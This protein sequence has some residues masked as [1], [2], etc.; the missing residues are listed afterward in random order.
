M[1]ALNLTG[2]LSAAFGWSALVWIPGMY[3]YGGGIAAGPVMKA[4]K[5]FDVKYPNLYGVPGIHKHADAFNGV[6]RG[7]QNFL[8]LS[9]MIQG[10]A[11]WGSLY[12]A[13]AAWA[14]VVGGLL[15]YAGSMLYA[16]AYAKHYKVEAGRYKTGGWIKY[17]GILA[18]LV[19]SVMTSLQLAGI[20]E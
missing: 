19:T 1:S 5:E 16:N 20:I 6:Q 7:H 18:A 14:N 4:R 15:F 3:I 2:N 8:E 9:H 11:L 12:S 10:M 17:F 13:N